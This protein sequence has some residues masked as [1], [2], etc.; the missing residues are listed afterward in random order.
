MK[1]PPMPIVVVLAILGVAFGVT[2]TQRDTRQPTPLAEERANRNDSTTT[3]VDV[4]LTNLLRTP[5]EF[6]GKAVRVSGVLM[7]GFPDGQTFFGRYYLKNTD[8]AIRL[9]P[10]IITETPPCPEGRCEEPKTMEQ[11]LDKKL[12]LTGTLQE[13]EPTD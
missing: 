12:R 10:W 13:I 6:R 9:I 5:N 2:L 11:L 4:T 1:K 8:G 7:G 3:A